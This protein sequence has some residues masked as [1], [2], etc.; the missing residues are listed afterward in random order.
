VDGW[1]CRHN[2]LRPFNLY[3]QE[4]SLDFCN[5]GRIYA[6][7]LSQSIASSWC[8]FYRSG[9]ICTP[10]AICL[11]LY[12]WALD[13]ALGQHPLT[14]LLCGCGKYPFYE[15]PFRTSHRN[16]WLESARSFCRNKKGGPQYPSEV[17]LVLLLSSG[18]GWD[19]SCAVWMI[20]QPFCLRSPPSSS[21][22][23]F[24]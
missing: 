17:A 4:G 12:T 3:H 21:D 13:Q 10:S 11:N 14:V 5:V 9:G 1:N 22:Y 16:I 24:P 8:A 19:M 23:G 7:R 2:S 15:L 20:S 18:R 6:E